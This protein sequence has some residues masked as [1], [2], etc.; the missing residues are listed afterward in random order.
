MGILDGML[1]QV[2]AN[3]D[4][5]NMASKV[6][7]DP[8]LA[9]KAVAAPGSAHSQPGDM[10]ETAAA[11]TGIDADTR[12]QVVQHPGGENAPVTSIKSCRITGKR[13]G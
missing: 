10:V 7:L 1:G 11:Q 5:A 13:R 12:T 6:G 3:A 2:T 8:A 9:E 4:I